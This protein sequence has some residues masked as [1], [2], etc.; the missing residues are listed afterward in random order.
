MCN[1]A[2][3]LNTLFLD[4]QPRPTFSIHLPRLLLLLFNN[5]F[6]PPSFNSTSSNSDIHHS[7][8]PA[9]FSRLSP[10]TSQSQ[11][12][13][14]VFCTFSSHPSVLQK[15]IP[16]SLMTHLFVFQM[17]IVSSSTLLCFRAC[18]SRKSKKYLTAGGTTAPKHST[19]RKKSS[20]NCC[21]VP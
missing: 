20:T 7:S 19:L 17:W 16:C 2:Q 10:T 15:T 5:L 4:I 11:T 13:V 3:P 14:V 1:P 9:Q 6:L 18:S 21:R 12:Q 8:S